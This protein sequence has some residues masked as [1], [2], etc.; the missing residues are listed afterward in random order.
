MFQE[1]Y[2]LE[3]VVWLVKAEPNPQHHLYIGLALETP[4]LTNC[5]HNL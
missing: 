3:W 1:G 5:M 4:S 2:N